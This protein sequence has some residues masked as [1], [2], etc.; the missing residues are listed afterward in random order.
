[1]IEAVE[2]TADRG[3]KVLF[4][5]LDA[6]DKDLIQEWSEAGVLPTFR[7]LFERAAW[8]TTTN[9][10]GLFVGAVWPSFFT[11]H[12]PDRH[13]RYC[14]AQLKPGTYE[15]YSFRPTHVKSEPFW[16]AIGKANRRVAI[17]DVP[18][19]YPYAGLNGIQL[20]DWGTHDRDD[21]FCTFPEALA[22]DVEARFGSHP[23]YKCDANRS[24]ET[25]FKSMR[26]ALLLGIKKKA[27]I[28]RHF[29]EQGPWDLFLTVFSE[30]HCAGHQCWHIHDPNH[31]RYDREIAQNVGDPLKDVYVA[32]DSAIAELL[33]A[34]GSETTVF[35]LASHGMGPHFDGTFLLDDI[36]KSL[37]KSST[38][39]PRRGV[40]RVLEWGWKKIP[41]AF[42]SSLRPVRRSAKS[43]LGS[44]ASD[45]EISECKCFPVQNNDV[46][47]AIRV[48]LIGREPHGRVRPG[49]EYDSFCEE[50]SRDLLDFI[51]LDTGQPLVAR[52]LRCDR[53]Y[54][55]NRGDLPDLLV[56]WNG[57]SPISN[58]YS[59]KTGRIQKDFPGN[60]T[61]DHKPEGLLFAVGPSVK[62]GKMEHPVSV[63]DFAVTFASLLDV[64]LPDT[65]GSVISFTDMGDASKR[66]LPV[67]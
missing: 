43:L 33:A 10:E 64:P 63:T 44:A 34:A 32:L 56:D 7:A 37:E 66:P 49:S 2:D 16:G 3:T 41:F 29:L 53:I 48:N 50:L 11:G 27:A 65:G 6:A 39:A 47:G 61:G 18:K 60:R 9:P 15:H 59:P 40:A 38:P 22:E 28:T 4:I 23:L 54:P 46:F 25:E 19:T 24:S 21:K 45:P 14:F 67:S 62:R 30:S 1:M 36:L 20:V 17:I 58:I 55:G 35:I 57:Q 42:R 51:N 5:G 26:D 13:G 12:S 31:P 52:V 8:T